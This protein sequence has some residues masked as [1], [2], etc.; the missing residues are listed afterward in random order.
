MTKQKD[1]SKYI[2]AVRNKKICET[3]EQ[4]KNFLSMD[5]LSK[6]FN[7]S[8]PQIYRIIRAGIIIKNYDNKR[9]SK[10]TR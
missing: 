6:V 8:L 4:E 5:D 2:I 7:L 9:T 3:W 1:N 10:R